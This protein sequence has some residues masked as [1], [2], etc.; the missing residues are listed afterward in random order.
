MLI[1]PTVDYDNILHGQFIL[2]V[3]EKLDDIIKKH[4]I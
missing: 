2:S 1:N 3:M 4:T